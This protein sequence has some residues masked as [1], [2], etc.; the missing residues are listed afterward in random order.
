[1]SGGQREKKK[2]RARKKKSEGRKMRNEGRE[3]KVKK[4]TRKVNFLR[5][6]FLAKKRIRIVKVVIFFD[7]VKKSLAK[8]KIKISGG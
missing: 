4:N 8:K 5:V 2:R 7:F 6:F 1:M 3:K